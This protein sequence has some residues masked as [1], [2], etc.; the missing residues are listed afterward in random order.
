MFPNILNK[1]IQHKYI[2][3][4]YKGHLEAAKPHGSSHYRDILHYTPPKELLAE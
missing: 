3:Y 4:R 2:K 1:F